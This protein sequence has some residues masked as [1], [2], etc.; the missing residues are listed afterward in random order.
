[1][2]A[3]KYFNIDTTNV[4]TLAAIE[5]PDGNNAAQIISSSPKCITICNFDASGDSCTIDLF[6][7]PSSGTD[8]YLLH[9][10]VIPGGVTLVLNEDELQYD[11]T[12]YALKFK[13]S[14]VSASQKVDIKITY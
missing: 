2:S 12:I 10:V 11:T 6:L 1:M 3:F 5:T 7:V 4:E 9:D 13:L 14:S 8:V